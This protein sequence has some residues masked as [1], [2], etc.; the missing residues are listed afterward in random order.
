VL[1]YIKAKNGERNCPARKSRKKG[2]SDDLIKK[3]VLLQTLRR[4][5]KK[6]QGRTILNSIHR[7]PSKVVAQGDTEKERKRIWLRN[8]L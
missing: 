8:Y 1:E 6:G 5:S 4:S 2:D 7:Y 3:I